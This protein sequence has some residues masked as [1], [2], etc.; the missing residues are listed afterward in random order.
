M[1]SIW[2]N[3]FGQI[4]IHIWKQMDVLSRFFLKKGK[5]LTKNWKKEEWIKGQ[6][7]E[8]R[9]KR[10]NGKN[11]KNRKKEKWSKKSIFHKRTTWVLHL[12][13]HLKI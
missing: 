4:S 12:I 3:K 1:N 9:E 5:N 7:R 13:F 8:K 6:R 10:E 2:G 11:D